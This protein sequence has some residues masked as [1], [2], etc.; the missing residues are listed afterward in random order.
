MFGSEIHYITKQTLDSAGR[1]IDTIQ[2]FTNLQSEIGKFVYE[3]LRQE[4]L[5]VTKQHM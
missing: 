3:D 4:K 5:I 2:Q 1:N